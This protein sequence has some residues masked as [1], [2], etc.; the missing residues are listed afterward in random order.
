MMMEFQ[1][2]ETLVQPASQ[3][4]KMQVAHASL[5]RLVRYSVRN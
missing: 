1:D 3:N 4:T 2:I 5:H